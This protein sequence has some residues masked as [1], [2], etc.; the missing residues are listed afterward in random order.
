MR[1]YF[2]RE[3]GTTKLGNRYA[4]LRDDVQSFHVTVQG[5]A[6]VIYDH[7][8]D[9]HSKEQMMELIEKLELELEPKLI[10]EETNATEG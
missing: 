3:K 5:P 7:F 10:P 9:V 4:I 6:M 2:E 1:L 8:T